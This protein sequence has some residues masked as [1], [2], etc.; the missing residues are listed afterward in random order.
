MSLFNSIR[1]G[2][3]G[4]VGYS[5]DDVWW[6]TQFKRWISNSSSWKSSWKLK[7]KIQLFRG[8]TSPS[9]LEFQCNSLLLVIDNS[10]TMTQ[11]PSVI[12]Y[13][14]LGADV[15]GRDPRG[16][17]TLRLVE[18]ISATT[19]PSTGT[20]SSDLIPNTPLTPL[21]DLTKVT[22]V[23]VKDLHQTIVIETG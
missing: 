21:N 1:R 5:W 10:Q 23:K 8:S 14:R 12:R 17:F 3:V 20:P 6:T 11:S 16:R 13:Y 9:C 19:T 4:H 18:N 7:N 22:V 2:L 15:S